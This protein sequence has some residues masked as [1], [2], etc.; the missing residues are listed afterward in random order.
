MTKFWSGKIQA[1]DRQVNFKGS[2][3]FFVMVVQYIQR[4]FN[5]TMKWHEWLLV[6]TFCTM[7]DMERL[8]KM[9]NTL[10]CMASDGTTISSF[11]WPASRVSM[12]VA[13]AIDGW[14]IKT[15]KS[16]TFCDTAS[17]NP[18]QH[19][20]DVSCKKRFFRHMHTD[21]HVHSLSLIWKLDCPL[22]R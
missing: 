2:I 16:H 12:F 13:L 21:Q 14:I 15:F 18:L 20:G 5:K 22:I 7:F 17:F 1:R 11:P 10:S 6:I 9:K 4:N 8:L 19:M 3:P